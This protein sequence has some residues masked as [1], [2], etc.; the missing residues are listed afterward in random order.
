MN[1]DVNSLYKHADGETK[2]KILHLC[3]IKDERTEDWVDGVV[4]S[5]A[6]NIRT[7]EIYVR[8]RENFSARFTEVRS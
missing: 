7:G 4:Y 8:T 2:Y 6:E 3:S 5:S 1:L